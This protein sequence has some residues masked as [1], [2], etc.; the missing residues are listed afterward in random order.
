MF[1][2]IRKH[3]T[4]LWIF[5]IG[6]T[7]VSFVVFFSPYTRMS[8]V[9][10]PVNLGSINGQ[11]ID[12]DQFR[13]A[14]REVSLQYFFNRGRWPDSQSTKDTHFDLNRETYFWLLLNQKSQQLGIHVSPEMVADFARAM[15][16]RFERA[17]ISSPQAFIT[18]VLAPRGL[19]ASDFEGF[20]RHLL[21][22]QE[23]I[24]TVAV[25]GLLVPPEEAKELY[26]RQ[27]QELA[28]EAVFF[29]AS[30]YVAN[31]PV[32]PESLS[33]FYSNHLAD[34][35][36][37][38]R[39][40][41]KYVEFPI[42]NSMTQAESELAKTNLADEVDATFD[43]LGTNYTTFGKTPKE[44]KAKIREELI[45]EKAALEEHRK[46]NDFATELYDKEPAR[47]EN[48]Q[49]LAKEK[50]LAVKET[51]PFTESDGPT[52]LDVG[53]GF[54]SAAFSLTPTNDPIAGP[55]PG[56]N[57]FY[58]IA[59]DK[60]LPSQIP[61]FKTIHDQVVADYKHEQA[62]RLARTAGEMAYGQFTN[63]IA[64]GKSFSD[65]VKQARLKPVEIPPF[66]ISTR[67]L[68]ELEGRASLGLVKETAFGL[69][70]GKMS[71]LEPTSE[72]GF[73]LYVKEKLPVNQAEMEAAMPAFLRHL[74]QT[75]QDDAFNEW[76]RKQA[77]IGL[78]DTPVF[79]EKRSA[80]AG[81]GA[82]GQS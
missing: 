31:I 3:Q 54:V 28:T 20:V 48:L 64:K 1:G 24:S 57:A 21:E 23:L 66:S 34:Y 61:K 65:A 73:I 43:R 11:P 68:P 13:Q 4:W 2:T 58:I 12:E 27:Y 52:N 53:S 42:S 15:L 81:A 56:Q 69:K 32:N 26:A 10:G 7:V 60:R 77:T 9:G 17:G 82:A 76:F 18:Q 40:Q 46:A 71:R 22:H 14:M 63:S 25:S 41:V 6:I 30:N 80:G 74:R 75:R 16:G 33:L 67:S 44:A 62:V 55:L 78:R 70:P 79:Q 51:P 50:G 38:E 36:I 72:G 49:D 8:S 19:Q 45:R 29:E 5:I 37:P 59:Y 47:P 39:V 35:R